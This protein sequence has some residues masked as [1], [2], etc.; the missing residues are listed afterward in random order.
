MGKLNTKKSKKKTMTSS[1]RKSMKGGALQAI[2]NFTT[3]SCDFDTNYRKKTAGLLGWTKK[4]LISLG[5]RSDFTKLENQKYMNIFKKNLE[6]FCYTN[7]NGR[8]LK[9][10]INFVKCANKPEKI[11]DLLYQMYIVSIAGKSS[12]EEDKTKVSGSSCP[13][14]EEKKYKLTGAQKA[15]YKKRLQNLDKYYIE[16]GEGP[17]SVDGETQYT[18]DNYC[19]SN[20]VEDYEKD[21]IQNVAKFLINVVKKSII[22][23]EKSK[24]PKEGE[25]SE[26]YMKD[27]LEKSFTNIFG[28]K[29]EFNKITQQ[30]LEELF[31]N[32]KKNILDYHEARIMSTTSEE[33]VDDDKSVKKSPFYMYVVFGAFIT[34]LVLESGYMAAPPGLAGGMS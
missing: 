32:K 34:A 31:K 29:F 18:K 30:S 28:E 19:Y 22:S 25:P 33:L 16:K 27:K 23:Y 12:S 15:L 17:K 21:N 3:E 11:H 9:F 1:K 5:D 8:Y 14:G 26:I 10:C 2:N 7:Q 13:Q 6:T 4:N 20:F 24:T